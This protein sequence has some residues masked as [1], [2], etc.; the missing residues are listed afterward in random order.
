[1]TPCQALE[2]LNHPVPNHPMGLC[3]YHLDQHEDGEVVK[4]K[5]KR[6]RPRLNEPVAEKAAKWSGMKDRAAAL[7]RKR[8]GI[9]PLTPGEQAAKLD[10]KRAKDRAR[11]YKPHTEAK[12]E[13]KQLIREGLNQRKQEAA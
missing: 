3:D 1:M 6:G 5:R 7:N 10:L 11:K 13:R 2:C 9:K 12:E 4:L 8:R